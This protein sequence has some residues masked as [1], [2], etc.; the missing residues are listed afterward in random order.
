[1]A[2]WPIIAEKIKRGRKGKFW[3]IPP[4]WSEDAKLQS[5]ETKDRRLSRIERQKSAQKSVA[6]ARKFRKVN[7][8]VDQIPFQF[9]E[10]KA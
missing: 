2:W 6:R 5:I 8:H 9:P 1:M 4:N 10:R 7:G 3:R